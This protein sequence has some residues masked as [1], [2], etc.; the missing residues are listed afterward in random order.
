MY[1][2]A[3]RCMTLTYLSKALIPGYELLE[4]IR[5][6]GYQAIT[7]SKLRLR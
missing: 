6:S 1:L 5:K 2:F 3:G 7:A 4:T